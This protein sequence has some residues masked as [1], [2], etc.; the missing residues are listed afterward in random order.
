[1]SYFQVIKDG[2]TGISSN[3]I[4]IKNQLGGISGQ[5]AKYNL[6]GISS[7]AKSIK[8]AV[9]IMDDWD[10][11]NYCNVNLNVAGTDVAA[12]AGTLNAQTVRVT[13]ATNDEVNNLLGTIDTDTS[14]IATSLGNM[15][16]SVDGNYLNINMNV[17]GTDVAGNAG[18]NTAQTIRTTIATNDACNR[19]LAGISSNSKLYA[20]DSA[21]TSADRGSLVLAVRKNVQTALAGTDGDYIPLTTNKSGQLRISD[22]VNYRAIAL[23]NVNHRY[24]GTAGSSS[25]WYEC[26]QYRQ[27][28]IGFELNVTS[29]PTD[30]L[31]S[32]HQDLGD[33]LARKLTNDFLGD[34]RYDDTCVTTAG[35]DECV[36]FPIACQRI[37]LNVLCAGTTT[38]ALFSV[39]SCYL[40]LRN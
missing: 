32:V 21:H 11:S 34:W 24:N 17:A 13:I 12:N 1:M 37:R 18:V 6:K 26:R 38:S 8:T 19:Y 30:I 28:S 22:D 25:S 16:N 27:A 14:N 40:Y 3:S 5:L 39:S 10:D 35:L 20:E 23:D 2:K 31:F 33:G 9:E 4:T 36:T 7:N 29:T 15:D